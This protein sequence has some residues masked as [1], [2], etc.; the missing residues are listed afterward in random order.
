MTREQEAVAR[1][2]FLYAQELLSWIRTQGVS[3]AY[4]ELYEDGS[5]RLIIGNKLQLTGALREQ[6]SLKLHS[7]RWEDD[8]KHKT[9]LHSCGGWHR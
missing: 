6:L 8:G 1:D 2:A 9:I 4:A 5:G 7:Q 3:T